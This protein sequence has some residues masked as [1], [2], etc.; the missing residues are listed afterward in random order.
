MTA[1][2]SVLE[3]SGGEGLRGPDLYFVARV[4][5]KALGNR[6]GYC[7]K[8]PRK[9]DHDGNKVTRASTPH[10]EGDKV[11][12]H[13]P[14]QVPEGAVLRLRGQGGLVEGGSPGDL[15]LEIEL[16]KPAI[17]FGVLV[18]WLLALLAGAAVAA[19]FVKV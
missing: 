5:P 9:L 19:F 16:V 11:R 8:V 17:T 10:D 3:P 4:P 15:L 18:L 6:E 1:I 14:P 12:L 2:G 13:L 7:V